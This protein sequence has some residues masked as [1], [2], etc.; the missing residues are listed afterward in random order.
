MDLTKPNT[1]VQ[2]QEMYYKQIAARTG[3]AEEILVG[4]HHAELQS[5]ADMTMQQMIL[6]LNA[7][8][9]S[10]KGGEEQSISDSRTTVFRFTA[11][12]RPWWISKRRWAKW[13]CDVV[14]IPRT[15][16]VAV[17]FTPEYTYPDCSMVFPK[18]ER[19]IRV[20]IPATDL[21]WHDGEMR[22][23]NDR[24]NEYG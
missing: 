14:E 2:L 23:Q 17:R 18:N 24:E 8:V 6:T 5:Y 12:R 19:V 10:S 13:K 3:V 1:T 11:P 15:L 9:L 4:L 16:E 20:A 21:R 7:Q 22:I